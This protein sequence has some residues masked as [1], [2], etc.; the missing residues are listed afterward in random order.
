M[1][2]NVTS[3]FAKVT[4]TS[5]TIQ[6]NSQCYPVEISDDAVPGNGFILYPLNH[7]SFTGNVYLRCIGGGGRARVNVVSFITDSGG[8]N[9]LSNP[10][11]TVTPAS[12]TLQLTG[13]TAS[14]TRNGSGTIIV[15]SD[16]AAVTPTVS[17]S[18]VTIPYAIFD[19]DTDVTISVSVVADSGYAADTKTFTVTYVSPLVVNMPFDTSTTQDLCGGTWTAY[20]SPSISS[21]QLYLPGNSS[22]VARNS[23]LTL[24]GK[25]FT[26]R[27]WFNMSSSSG[28]YARVFTLYTTANS[29]SDSI[30]FARVSTDEQIDFGIF[31]TPVRCDI[32]LGEIHHFEFDYIHSQGATKCFI[33]GVLQ[34]TISKSVS[35]MTFAKCQL[36]RSEYSANGYYIGT[37]DDF[38]IYDGVA[39]HTANFT[40]PARSSA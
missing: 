31:G 30:V 2:Y 35:Q 11:L 15:S 27:G 36:G 40:P 20:G 10:E 23:S 39:L 24:G 1:L 13:T 3:E 32:T 14:V 26:I 18:T 8:I 29:G 33:D 38:K 22:Y 16:N 7:I 19:E 9:E 34:G 25:D 17:G 37:I 5:G 4:E 28:D 6:N 12:T 21:K